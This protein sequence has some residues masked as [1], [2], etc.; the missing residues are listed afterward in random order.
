MKY[1]ILFLGL[2]LIFSNCKIEPP[3]AKTPRKIN[4]IVLLDLSDRLLSENQ[5][6]N[7]IEIIKSL[8]KVFKDTVRLNKHFIQS[9]DYFKIRIAYQK[10]SKINF[11]DFEN[12]LSVNMDK[13][14]LNKKKSAINNLENSLDSLLNSLYKNAR[15]SENSNDY[16]G[17]DIWKYFN[18]GLETDLVNDSLTTNYLFIITDGYLYFENFGRTL[19][20]KNRFSSCEF[21]NE[22]RDYGWEQKFDKKDYGL[23]P[24][25]KKIDNVNVMILQ[26]NPDSDFVNEYDLLSRI[27][28]KWLSEMNISKIKINK[29]SSINKTNDEITDFLKEKNLLAIPFSNN[30]FTEKTDNEI[31]INPSD[32]ST[33]SSKNDKEIVL[34]DKIVDKIQKKQ[35]YVIQNEADKVLLEMQ[36]ILE[37]LNNQLNSNDSGSEILATLKILLIKQSDL[38]K[39]YLQN[40]LEFKVE[41]SRIEQTIQQFK[42][43]ITKLQNQ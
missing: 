11:S 23:I 24:I 36:P 27:W 17:A 37:K 39:I 33:K 19:K 25:N 42:N 40:E 2:V 43:Q 4:F 1:S 18:E 21:M 22:L 14:P 30:N 31:T 41:I 13:L 7:D 15:V 5:Q 16:F 10:N 38:K 35:K 3:T 12:K 29:K 28:F 6:I 34:S 26:T 8:F 9:S 32:N 20:S